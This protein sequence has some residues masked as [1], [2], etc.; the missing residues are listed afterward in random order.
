VEKRLAI[1]RQDLIMVF[2]KAK[3]LTNQFWRLEKDVQA[4][5]EKE[6]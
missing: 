2:R 4:L 6:P 1:L 3:E 5:K